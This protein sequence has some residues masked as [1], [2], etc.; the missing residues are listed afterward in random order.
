VTEIQMGT[1]MAKQTYEKLRLKPGYTIA[2]INSPTEYEKVVG[3]L[4]N[5]IVIVEEPTDKVDFVHLFIKNK[6]ELDAFIDQALDAIKYDGMLWVSYPKGSSKVK[7]DV[8]RDILWELLLEKGIRPVMQ[9]SIDST[10]SAI[11][12][13]PE[14]AVG[15]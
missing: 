4:P 8:N 9:I 15:T 1:A 7:T 3:T 5:N 2:V 13:R 12:F 11:R 6:S 10:W 14:G